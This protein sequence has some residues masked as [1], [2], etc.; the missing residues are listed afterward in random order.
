MR[1]LDV[2]DAVRDGSF[3]DFKHFYDGDINQVDSGLDL[4]LLCMAMTN[5]RNP[6]EKLKIIKFLLEENIDINYTTSKEKRN[7][8]HMFYFCVLRPTIAYELEIT[9]LLL[10]YEININALDQ[11]NAIPLKYAITINKLSTEDNKEMY[12]LLI[13]SGS[14]VH[15]KDAFG[16]SCMDYAKEYFWRNELVTINEE[17]NNEN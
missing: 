9:R 11:Y 16:K 14:K 8:L 13:S 3:K 7:A 12:K 1:I 5:D 10:D 4:N 15:L 17:C 6:S 2:F